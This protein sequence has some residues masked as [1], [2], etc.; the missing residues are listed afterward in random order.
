MIGKI[1]GTITPLLVCG[2]MAL[3]LSG[4]GDTATEDMAYMDDSTLKMVELN[5]LEDFRGSFAGRDM[6][7]DEYTIE[8]F[9][10]VWQMPEL[11]TGCEVTALDMVLEYYGVGVDKVELAVN[12][13]PTASMEL[14]EGGDGLLY[15]PNLNEAFIGD[16]TSEWGVICGVSAIVSAADSYLQERGSSLRTLDL[17]GSSPEELYSL[18]REGTPVVVWV[19]INMEDRYDTHG[20]Y[21]SMGE[22][23]DWSENDHGAVLIGYG[24]D[25]VVIADPLAGIVEYRRRQF[26]YVFDSRGRQCAILAA[27]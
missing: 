5:S 21:T 7:L 13:L 18:V 11:P 25:T 19:T 15:G 24:D 23:V 2:I 3:E 22:Y 9:P 20:W 6:L 12:Y 1:L 10:I 4:C 14:Y 26:E 17:T 16:P 27:I 8:D